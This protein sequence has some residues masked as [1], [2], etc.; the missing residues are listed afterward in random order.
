MVKSAL[1]HN[2]ASQSK[3]NWSISCSS[4]GKSTL[5]LLCR[6]NDKIF[7][8]T[9][10]HIDSAGILLLGLPETA[11]VVIS[12]PSVSGN[13]SSRLDDWLETAITRRNQSVA[14][15]RYARVVDRAGPR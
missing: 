14:S 6:M 9:E 4:E 3:L 15:P 11:A 1:S 7:R 2:G 10:A 8:Q 5:E 13:I 12:S